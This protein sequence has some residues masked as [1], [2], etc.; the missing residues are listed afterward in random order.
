[1]RLSRTGP[2]QEQK[3]GKTSL[4]TGKHALS[5]SGSYG[6]LRKERRKTQHH[7]GSMGGNRLLGSTYGLRLG[8]AV[9]L[10]L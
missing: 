7:N 10:F 1:M 3:N 4:E 8:Q 5:A 9:P 6:K 2:A